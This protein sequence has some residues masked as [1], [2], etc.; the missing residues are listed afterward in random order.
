MTQLP[1][2]EKHLPSFS[3]LNCQFFG[4]RS[5]YASWFSSSNGTIGCV[6][7]FQFVF[8]MSRVLLRTYGTHSARLCASQPARTSF[9]RPISTLSSNPKI[10]S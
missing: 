9:L 4:A 1:A 7:G 6:L 10:V 8:T 5:I 3:D 2:A